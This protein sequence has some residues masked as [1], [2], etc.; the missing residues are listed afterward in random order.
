MTDLLKDVLDTLNSLPNRKVKGK[1]WTTYDLAKRVEYEIEKDIVPSLF[2]KVDVTI[3]CK[4]DDVKRISD[5]LLDLQLGVYSLG[6]RVSELTQRDYNEVM[7]MVPEDVMND[8][9]KEELENER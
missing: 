6:T 1:D 5:E 7:F 3:I 9:L 2:K 8:Y 4:D